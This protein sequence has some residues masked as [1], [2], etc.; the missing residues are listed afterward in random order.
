MNFL[1][2]MV[3]LFI[4][5]TLVFSINIPNLASDSLVLQK[6]YVFIIITCYY[7]V[8]NIILS[9]AIDKDGRSIKQL[10]KDAMNSAVPGLFGFVLFTDLRVMGASK[11]F[12]SRITNT[13]PSSGTTDSGETATTTTSMFNFQL[14]YIISLFIVFFYFIMYLYRSILE[15]E[16]Y[17]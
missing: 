12:I 4:I 10:V 14:S 5:L 6:I 17:K 3:M 1:L 16:T 7:F 2:D 9:K 15:N 11:E 8:Q 13:V